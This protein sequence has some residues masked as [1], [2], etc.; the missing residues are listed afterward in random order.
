VYSLTEGLQQ[1]LCINFPSV[2]EADQDDFM[3]LDATGPIAI[4]IAVGFPIS[5]ALLI[6]ELVEYKGDSRGLK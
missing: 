6:P 5:V 2:Q 4:G 1:W 3:T